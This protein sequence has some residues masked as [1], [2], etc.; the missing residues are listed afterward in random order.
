MQGM[1]SAPVS[2]PASA[3]DGAPNA[4]AA[5]I[6]RH[7]PDDGIHASAIAGVSLI[8]AAAPTMPMPAV[9]TPTLCLVA[10]GSKEA[11]LGRTAYRYDPAHDL[12]ASVDLPVMGA[13]VKASAAQPYLC[14]QLR[15]DTAVLAE[16]ALAHP[17]W[18]APAEAA[19]PAGLSLHRTTPA[20][21]D[22]AIRLVN[23][24]D[25][26]AD[27]PA[28]APLVIR[29]MLYRLLTGPHASL[30]RQMAQA[31]SR[32]NQISRAIVW[33]RTHFREPCRIEDAAAVAGMSRSSFHHHFKAVTQLSP[34]AFRTRLRMQE[35]CRLMLG[36]A[37]DAAQA[38]FRVG[39]DSPSQFSRDYT[40]LFGMPPARHASQ[41]RASR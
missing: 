19:Q 39:Y 16:L 17:A 3:S 9:Y 22:T 27:I 41:L 32:L 34:I 30:V 12:I 10:Q 24:L 20:L 31:D 4:L 23:L 2:A 1:P 18:P 21:W 38:G 26:P 25:A 29:E 14:L 40:R 36:E 35:A 15:L 6:A 13:V 37:L 33:M 7:A 8:R 28:L 11:I 5:A